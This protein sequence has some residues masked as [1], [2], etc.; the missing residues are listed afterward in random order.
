MKDICKTCLKSGKCYFERNNLVCKKLLEE[1]RGDKKEN[2]ARIELQ[3]HKDR[4]ELKNN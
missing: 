4:A 1:V 3:R 2:E